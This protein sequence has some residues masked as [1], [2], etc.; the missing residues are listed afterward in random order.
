MNKYLPLQW[1]GF[2]SSS[3]HNPFSCGG[4]DYAGAW[5]LHI[6]QPLISWWITSPLGYVTCMNNRHPESTI[7][8]PFGQ[9]QDQSKT[10]GRSRAI[11][12]MWHTVHMCKR[13]HTHPGSAGN[14]GWTVIT[15]RCVSC[16][17]FR[18]V[19][20][21]YHMHELS[22][23]AK[24]RGGGRRTEKDFCRRR[25]LFSFQTIFF[26][27]PRAISFNNSQRYIVATA[28]NM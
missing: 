7:I 20:A 26:F 28:C 16:G 8:F 10:G 3:S 22:Q 21:I 12:N 25:N 14:Q 9:H 6:L 15:S 2:Y 17:I 11:V 5:L 1:H 19:R 24:D 18:L 27:L 4:Y 23:H 13:R